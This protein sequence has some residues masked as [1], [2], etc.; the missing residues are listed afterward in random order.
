QDY[1]AVGRIPFLVPV[2]WEDGWPVL[3]IGGKV[4]ATLNLPA[5]KSLMP[6]I[7]NSDDFDR[8]PGDEALPLVW[9]WNHNP[10]NNLWSVTARAG[11][12][13][14]HTGDRT[15]D[16]LSAK[17]TLTQRTVGPTCSAAIA[18][19]VSNMK[20]GDFAGLSLLQKN[21]GLVGVRMEGNA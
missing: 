14:M 1:G 10:D 4:P 9:Q 16:F 20:D 13:T 7:V 21:Y 2:T 17:N 11:S 3:G 6:G 8:K 19:E 15:D 12:L 18:I 5:N